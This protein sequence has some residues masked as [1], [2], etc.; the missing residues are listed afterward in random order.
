MYM[1]ATNILNLTRFDGAASSSQR[2]N[3]MPV[4][5]M[6]VRCCVCSGMVGIYN[7][8]DDDDR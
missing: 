7:D 1:G 6:R 4:A 3:S 5:K 2:G 8:D